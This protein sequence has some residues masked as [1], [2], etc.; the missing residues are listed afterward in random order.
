MY[1]VN[2][3][4]KYTSGCDA[5][6]LSRMKVGNCLYNSISFT[7]ILGMQKREY[8][9]QEGCE[10]FPSPPHSGKNNTFYHEAAAL[11]PDTRTDHSPRNP[12]HL[13]LLCLLPHNL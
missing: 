6:Q 10:T 4:G 2:N 1:P 3:S 12:L 5:V 13:P 7:I 8:C 11:V 9:K